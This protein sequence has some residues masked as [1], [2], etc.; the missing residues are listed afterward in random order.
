MSATDVAALVHDCMMVIMK[1]ALPV[2]GVA[3]VVGLL[4]SFI[5]A[6][7]QINEATLAFLPKVA[8]IGL[9][10]LLLGSY[11]ATTLGDFTRHLFDRIIAV[12]GS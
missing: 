4:I 9:S 3:L 2:L 10:L 12:G 1:I 11:M 5:Q 6:I 8:A 7:T